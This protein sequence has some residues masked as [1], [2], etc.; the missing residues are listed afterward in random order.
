MRRRTEMSRAYLTRR[1]FL[2][3][4]GALGAAGLLA[5]CAA[6]APTPTP[7]P[8]KPAA[9]PAPA[10]PAAAPTAAPATAATAA[11]AQAPVQPTAA[12]TAVPAPP[13]AAP[14]T[15]APT[16][17][18]APEL[19]YFFGTRVAL[20][21][22]G[23]VQDA[24]NVTLKERINATINMQPIDWG[25]YNDKMTAKNAAGEKYDL[26]FT[27]SWINNYLDNVKNGV[28]LDITD[29]LPTLAPKFYGG[30]NPAAWNATKVK[31]HIYAAVNQQIWA[32]VIGPLARKDMAEKY[33]LDLTKVQKFEDLEPWWSAIVKGEA[34]KVTPLRPQS[35]WW[36]TYRDLEIR[37]QEIEKAVGMLEGLREGRRG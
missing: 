7:E 27:A 10:Q 29:L 16:K 15:A 17:G 21:D 37:N 30:L 11:P 12:P 3:G 5:A 13:T 14:A 33:S 4:V 1:G 2:A 19:I 23:Q 9:A 25:A 22:Q 31:G 32:S 20:K 18:P 36:T 24:M 35:P 8:T 34:G 6:S 26:A 28:L